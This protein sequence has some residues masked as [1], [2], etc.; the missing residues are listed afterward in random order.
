MRRIASVFC[1]NR[2]KNNRFL[3]SLNLIHKVYYKS[4]SLH[5]PF[6]SLH[7]QLVLDILPLLSL[8]KGRLDFPLL[9]SRLIKFR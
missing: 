9:F 5:T 4:S 2:T 6:F 8:K 7:L 3:I 1:L